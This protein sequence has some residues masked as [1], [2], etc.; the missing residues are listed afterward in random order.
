M[1]AHPRPGLTDRETQ[2]L[3]GIVDGLTDRLI[4]ARL[5]ISPNTVHLHVHHILRKLG[6]RTRYAAAATV[7]QVKR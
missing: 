6:V 3:A 1:S 5:G 7:R 2:V 4:G